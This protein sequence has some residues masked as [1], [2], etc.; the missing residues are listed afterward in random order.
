ML[1]YNTTNTR[2]VLTSLGQCVR[3]GRRWGRR[4]RRG[5]KRW[6]EG[7]GGG[8]Q[9]TGQEKGTVEAKKEKEHRQKGKQLAIN[10]KIKM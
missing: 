8:E 7:G 2:K 4:G 6:E 5:G 9:E 10:A 1:G 3:V